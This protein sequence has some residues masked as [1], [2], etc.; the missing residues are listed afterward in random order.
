MYRI[1]EGSTQGLR[2]AE[3]F[4][5]TLSALDHHPAQEVR[6]LFD[7]EME[8]V[9]ARAPGRLDVLGGIAD[10]SGS[11][12]LQLPTEEAALVALQRSRE[13][14]LRVVSLRASV[15]VHA[16]VFE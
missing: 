13:R 8:I 15:G 10:Y 1:A 7:R 12:V 2:D 4:V 9:L 6:A 3:R 16:S 5:E 11:L 14:V